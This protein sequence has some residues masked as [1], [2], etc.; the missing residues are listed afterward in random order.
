[1]LHGDDHQRGR[2]GP[3]RQFRQFLQK[4]RIPVRARC[5]EILEVLAELVD[6]EED[7]M[8]LSHTLDAF[9]DFYR[10]GLA[11]CRDEPLGDQILFE[12]VLP[13]S[14]RM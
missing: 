8:R 1:M 5:R 3:L 13:R 12:T 6:N 2:V 11:L 10:T 4:E 7:R 9:A 14:P